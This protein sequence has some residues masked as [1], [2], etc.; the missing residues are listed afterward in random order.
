MRTWLPGLRGRASR[1]LR[2]AWRYSPPVILAASFA[3]LILLGA[4]LLWTPWASPAQDL[5]FWQ[6]L[7]TACSAVTVTGLVVVDTGAE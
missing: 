5:S 7:F 2:R 4:L 3:V 1:Q 6:A